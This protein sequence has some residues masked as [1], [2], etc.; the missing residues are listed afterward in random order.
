M[1][2]VAESSTDPAA[3]PSAASAATA[4]ASSPRV[5]GSRGGGGL[6][7][8]LLTL[9]VLA[10]LGAAGYAG[11]LWWQQRVAL[12]DQAAAQQSLL[13]E[14]GNKVA[15]LE[16]ETSE[17]GTRFA[18]QSRLTDR[19]GTDIAALQSRIEDSLSLMSRISEDLSGGR[20]RFQLTSVEQLLILA[21]DRLQLHR[22]V[23]SALSALDSAD[24]RLAKL[25]DPQLFPVREALAQER[26][27]LRAVPMPDIAS[28]SLTLSS[29]IERVPQ[30]PLG[31]HA[32]AQFHSPGARDGGS[33]SDAESGWRRLLGAVQTAVKSL[34]TIRRED[35]ARAL[36]MLPPE[37]E[38]VV[39][40]VLTLKLE[41][42]RVALLTSNTVAMREELR[43]ASGWLEAEF[44]Q[45]DPGVLAIDAE[46]ERLQSLELAPPLPDVSRSLAA[47]RARLDAQP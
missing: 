34:F 21:N 36:R 1:T 27:A 22:D 20:T 11:W 40:N 37:A 2:P 42:A 8:A 29:L 4:S 35:N 41:G 46:L 13:H 28:A 26:T 32:P 47:L 17:L 12:A 25:S 31:S 18:D 43:S 3:E 10:L 24:E 5:A 33:N 6:L 16:A 14:L 45:D 38:A 15:A 39:Y 9:V 23:R 7:R 30:L 19:N 44:K